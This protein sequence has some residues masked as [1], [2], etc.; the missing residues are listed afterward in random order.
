MYQ[1]LTEHDYCEC[2]GLLGYVW[3]RGKDMIFRTCR[4]RKKDTKVEVE[5]VKY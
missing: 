2:G 1:E 4:K 5:V 3:Y